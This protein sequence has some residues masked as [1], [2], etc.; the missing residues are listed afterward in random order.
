MS[1]I[2]CFIL[3][4]PYIGLMVRVQQTHTKEFIYIRTNRQTLLKVHFNILYCMKYDEI[5]S[6]IGLQKG[7][8]VML[9]SLRVL[10]DFT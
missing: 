8:I 6:L 2:T 3:K 4:I 9:F 1:D 10:K 7:K 5:N